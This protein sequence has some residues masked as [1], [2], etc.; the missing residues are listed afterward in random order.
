M[1]D[2]LP[3]S[4]VAPTSSGTGGF[5]HPEGIIGRLDIRPGMV[6]ADFGA[7]S[8]Y[9]SIPAARRVGEGGKVYAI[10]IQ[11]TAINLL[12]SKASLEHLLNIEAVWADLE[13]PAGS[14]LAEG[15]VDF[16]IIA[17][18]LFQAAEKA[19]VLAEAKRVLRTGGKLAILE[20]DETP[21][22]AGPPAAL[23]VPKSLVRQLTEGVGFQLEK[24]FEAGSH[25]YG[26]LFVKK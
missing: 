25:H 12:R 13:R 14:R 16:V 10:D 24:E 18:I 21:F 1:T 4:P 8:G 22:P 20:W 5:L 2:R 11:Q 9:F 3:P 6:V 23:R 19:A 26:L 15:A 17:N 7:G